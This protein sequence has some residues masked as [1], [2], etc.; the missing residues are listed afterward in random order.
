MK[1]LNAID[2]LFTL[3]VFI[4]IFLW[5]VTNTIGRHTVGNDT[6]EAFNW[7][8]SLS[9][10]YDKNPYMPGIIAYLAMLI[11]GKAK[12]AWGYYLIQQ[13]FIGMGFCGIYALGKKLVSEQ[14]ALISVLVLEGCL[15][16]NAD[17][18]SNNDNYI[19]IGLIPWSV[20]F[21]YRITQGQSERCIDWVLFGVFAGLAT[22]TKYSYLIILLSM[23]VYISFSPRTLKHCLQQRSNLFWL[24]ISYVLVCI[25]NLI[26]LINNDFTAL[27]YIIKRSSNSEQVDFINSH[28]YE[29]LNFVWMTA[30]NIVLVFI[31]FLIAKPSRVIGSSD[32]KRFILYIGLL[33]INILIFYYVIFGGPTYWEW[34]VPFV[35][36]LGTALVVSFDTKARSTR[37]YIISLLLI[38]LGSTVNLFINKIFPRGN[39]DFPALEI[40]RYAQQI[41][42]E[43]TE[44]PLKYIAGSRYLA[45]YISYY[46]ASHPSVYAEWNPLYSHGINDCAILKHG[47]LFVHNG[48]YGTSVKT[49]SLDYYN[50]DNFPKEIYH[51]FPSLKIL[52]KKTFHYYGKNSNKTTILFG[53]IKPNPQ[54][55]CSN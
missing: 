2:I 23:I 25:P 29:P 1:K 43:N 28:F 8:S 38:L 22:M 14:K 47:A 41:W 48:N 33:P 45:G 50:F 54:L 10:G 19:L 36:Y 24:L 6:I 5:T 42:K 37:L 30:C 31:L 4:H 20:L 13:L 27:K 44:M 21:F 40:A 9:F 11:S 49:L 32:N 18:Q 35:L 55:S 34:G 53:I 3:F 51:R 15:Y 39:S 26:W 12:N 52:S 17:V 16:F 46:S 7:G